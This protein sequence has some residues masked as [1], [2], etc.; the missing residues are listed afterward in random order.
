MTTTAIEDWHSLA[1]LKRKIDTPVSVS[2]ERVIELDDEIRRLR[3]V[4]TEAV[5]YEGSLI[6]SR[7]GTTDP[8]PDGITPEWYKHARAALAPAARPAR[9]TAAKQKEQR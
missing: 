2:A 3:R 4:L 6:Y 5:E 7:H 9:T 1:K 8:V